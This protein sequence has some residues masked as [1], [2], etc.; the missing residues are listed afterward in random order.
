MPVL[1]RP[2]LDYWLKLLDRGPVPSQVWVNT[3]YLS[4]QVQTFLRASNAAYPQLSIEITTESKLLGTAG[5]LIELLPKLKPEQDLLLVHAD[6]LSWFSLEAFLNA[7]RQRPG[8]T[9]LTMMTFETD[10][11]Q[12]CGIVET[13]ERDVLKAFHEKVENPPSNMANGAVYFISPEGLAHIR[14][15][16]NVHD[17]STEVVPAFLE[18]IYCWQNTT[19][20]RDIGNPMAYKIAH[21]E[22]RPVAEHYELDKP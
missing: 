16:G 20:H 4:E 19:Y 12:S 22:F 2:L 21:R 17:F 9:E 11:P 14:E 10:A 1:G 18:K 8:G 13:D 7:H 5:T 6:N 3:F 15:L